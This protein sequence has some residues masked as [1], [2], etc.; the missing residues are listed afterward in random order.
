ML[1]PNA[2]EL[3]RI[4]D[5][6]RTRQRFVISSH[7][8]PDGDSIGSQ[9]AM[10]YA[11]EAMGKDVTI[12]NKDRATEPIMA[13]P[14]V[15]GIEIAPA[16]SGDF[17]AAIIM[18]CGDLSRPG[19]DGLDRYFVINIDHHPGNTE[20]GDLNWFDQSAAACG[21]MVFDLIVALGV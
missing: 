13:F 6:I 20:Y 18:E 14:G 21:E 3:T 17:D 2:P 8:R 4:V 10:A 5:A 1:M 12:V 7:A 19:V 11:L 15:S 16:V 9:L